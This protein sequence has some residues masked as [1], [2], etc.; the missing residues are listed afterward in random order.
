MPVPPTRFY[1]DSLNTPSLFP[2][3][4][5]VLGAHEV[6]ALG[7]LVEVDDQPLARDAVLGF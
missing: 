5:K 1:T 6:A 3:R 2:A 4:H 7:V